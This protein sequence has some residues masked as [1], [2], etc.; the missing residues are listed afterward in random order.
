MTTTFAQLG[1]PSFICDALERRGIT[2]T[3]AIQ[4]A[5]IDDAL[6]GR[7]VCGRAPTGSGKT[8]A[9]GV[10]MI[11]TA[12]RAESHLPTALVLA[13]TRELAEQI[14]NELRTFSGRLRVD[15]VYG[16]VGYGKQVSALRR[17]VDV[18]V[19]CPGRLEDLIA[20]GDVGLSDV[21]I[22]VLDEADR[23]ADMGFMPAVRR[24]LP[25]TAEERQT[26]L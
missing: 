22:V 7:D 19:A 11:A 1:V 20:R 4:A 24:I 18:L 5:T 13:P 26:V 8:L 17:G 6:A 3:F 10:P 25:Q 9:F 14:T 23:M 2:E 21:D 15:A 12:T 16:G